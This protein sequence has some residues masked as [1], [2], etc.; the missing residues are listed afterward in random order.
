MGCSG[1]DKDP[2]TSQFL[3]HIKVPFDQIVGRY[4][5]TG[6]LLLIPIKG[7]GNANMTFSERTDQILTRWPLGRS[8]LID[9]R[10]CS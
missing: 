10:S 7:S 9:L 8:L 3:L 6:K 4:D 2:K 1:F 5:M